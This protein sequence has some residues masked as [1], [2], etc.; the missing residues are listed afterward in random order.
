MRP[1]T[2]SAPPGSEPEKAAATHDEELKPQPS[3]TEELLAAL[4]ALLT[5]ALKKV[6]NVAHATWEEPI[7]KG[8][9]KTRYLE[10]V[11]GYEYRILKSKCP[12]LR[13]HLESD[14]R[15][16]PERS[17]YM[18]LDAMGLWRKLKA[19]SV[20]LNTWAKPVEKA[21]I[22]DYMTARKRILAGELMYVENVADIELGGKWRMVPKFDKEKRVNDVKWV[23]E[24]EPDWEG[25]AAL[26]LS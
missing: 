10:L 18:V 4:E 8:S 26:F 17:F 7:H 25:L 16:K 1:S 20:V 15:E 19:H 23:K 21:I 11:A 6:H 14:P 22:K 5:A 24:Y 2:D 13:K 9:V 3:S 12:T